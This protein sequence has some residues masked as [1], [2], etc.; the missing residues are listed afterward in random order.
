MWQLKKK[1]CLFVV[2]KIELNRRQQIN[3]RV[4]SI[5]I[6]LRCEAKWSGS[7]QVGYRKWA[8]V[9]LTEHCRQVFAT[10]AASTITVRKRLR[11]SLISK[12][13]KRRFSAAEDEAPVMLM[14]IS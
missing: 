3:P 1:R 8:D 10:S 2:V 4:I 9:S 14:L 7:R 13:K 5:E 6:E 12:H 11:V